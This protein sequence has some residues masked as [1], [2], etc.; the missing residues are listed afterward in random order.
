V[1]S[2]ALGPLIPH[3]LDPDLLRPDSWL[4]AISNIGQSRRSPR[5]A[6]R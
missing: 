1:S 5:A 3:A 4:P 6:D 2:G